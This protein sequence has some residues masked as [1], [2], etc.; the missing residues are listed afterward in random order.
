MLELNRNH[1]LLVG[2]I[3]VAMG[4]QFR[5]VESFVLNEQT[6]AMIAKRL[7][8]PDSAATTFMPVF[9]SS[10]PVSSRVITPPRWI[11]FMMIS[12]GAVLILHS[13]IMPRPQ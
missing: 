5:M 13:L 10:P 2:T 6:T 8:K 11:G 7:N 4:I 1:Y 3:L 9:N 12:V